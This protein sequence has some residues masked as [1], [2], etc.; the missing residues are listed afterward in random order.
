LATRPA[1]GAE[2]PHRAAEV[3]RRRDDGDAVL[4][5]ELLQRP[6]VLGAAAGRGGGEGSALYDVWEALAPMTGQLAAG[7]VEEPAMRSLRRLA[8]EP[9]AA[10]PDELLDVLEQLFDG[11]SASDSHAPGSTCHLT[12]ASRRL[13]RLDLGGAVLHGEVED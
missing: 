10:G 5:R 12:I 13:R 8:T 6:V 9:T 7:R 3:S 4:G 2:D 1:A 11:G